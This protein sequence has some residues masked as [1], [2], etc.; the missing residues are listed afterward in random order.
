MGDHNKKEI[1][2]KNAEPN[3]T[4]QTPMDTTN[5]VDGTFK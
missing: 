3:R 4:E 2:S 5:E 1:K